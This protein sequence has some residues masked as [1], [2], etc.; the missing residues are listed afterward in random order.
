MLNVAQKVLLTNGLFC[1]CGQV[2][3][4]RGPSATITARGEGHL[5]GVQTTLIPTISCLEKHG[6][7]NW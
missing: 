2:K 3:L 6:K 7:S 5:Y 1:H 4:T